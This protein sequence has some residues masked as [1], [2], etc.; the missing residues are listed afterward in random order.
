[1]NTEQ[2]TKAILV[3]QIGEIEMDTKMMMELRKPQVLR[4]YDYDVHFFDG[5]TNL[6]TLS[7]YIQRFHID[8]FAVNITLAKYIQNAKHTMNYLKNKNSNLKIV[9]TGESVTQEIAFD[10][11]ADRYTKNGNDIAVILES[12]DKK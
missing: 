9:C 2:T 5:K 8:Y 1:M 11:G 6:R 4:I 12:L 7:Y 3:C 10:I